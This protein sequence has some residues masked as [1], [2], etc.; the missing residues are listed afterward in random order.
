MLGDSLAQ[1]CQLAWLSACSKVT[2]SGEDW[3]AAM[4]LV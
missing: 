1:G 3:L 4:S 2:F